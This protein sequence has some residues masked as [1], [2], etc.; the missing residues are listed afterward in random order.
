MPFLPSLS[1]A[2]SLL[3]VFRAFPETS[4]PLLEFHEVLLRGPSPFTEAERELI[5]AYVSG[6]NRCRYCHGVHS[7]TAE[8]LGVPHG[9]MPQLLD[10]I[11]AAPVPDRMRPVLH[12]AEKLTRHPDG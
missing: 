6:L 7:A 2:S 8:R 1:G 11:D 3:D 10:G 5:A 9:L 12:Y 4:K